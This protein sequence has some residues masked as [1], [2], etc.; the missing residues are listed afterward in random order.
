MS[1]ACSA[2]IIGALMLA[3]VTVM[4]GKTTTPP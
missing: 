2:S 1:N 3:A 4:T